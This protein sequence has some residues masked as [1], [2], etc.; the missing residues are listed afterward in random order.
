M[1]VHGVIREIGY[2]SFLFAVSHI[3]SKI[4]VKKKKFE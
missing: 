4:F 2:F 1:T 3:Q